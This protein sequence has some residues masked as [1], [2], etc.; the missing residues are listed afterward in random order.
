MET[1]SSQTETDVWPQIAPL[2][3]EA[4][5]RLSSADRNAIVLRYYQ[6]KSLE[7]TSQAL[8]VNPKAAQKRVTRAV[9]KLRQFL[10]K[11]GVTLTAAVIASA[12]AANSVQAAPVG[13]VATVKA[14]AQGTSISA[15]ITAL[16]NGTMKTMTW[17]K[18]KFA[19]SIGIVALLA[20]GVVKV[21]ISQT[22]HS[23]RLGAP[24][25][26]KRSQAA[27]A[28]L[29]S[30]SDEGKTV[31]SL[32]TNPTTFSIKLA[33]PNLYH[34]GWT[35]DRGFFTGTGLVWSA[36]SGY[37]YKMD[38]FNTPIKNDN[39]DMSLISA[40]GVS[41][42]AAASIPGTFFNLHW[43]NKLGA[44]MQ[45]AIIKPDEKIDAVDCYVLTQKN[46]GGTQTLW[47]GKQDFL[48][49]Q[50]EGDCSLADIIASMEALAKQHPGIKL[51]PNMGGYIKTVETHRN[52]VTNPPLTESDFAP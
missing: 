26:I 15:T 10:L 35:G 12:V 23:G 1:L 30:Y 4:V 21:A 37:F 3:D 43:G 27:Y 46:A 28:A 9:D 39:M 51:L 41:G 50:I 52:I 24:E 48:I 16:V 6:Q 2:L 32:G 38:Q 47:I 29:T 40:I 49:R 7:E 13:L 42:G 33:R 25:I 19:M 8:G 18:L 11:R 44:A 17:L 45:T 36:G 20:G 5:A 14:S 34:I 22:S 31:F